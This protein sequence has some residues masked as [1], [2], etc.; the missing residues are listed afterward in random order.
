MTQSLFTPIITHLTPFMGKK[1]S[2]LEFTGVDETGVKYAIRTVS[3]RR[4]KNAPATE[5]FCYALCRLTGIATPEFDIVS[6]TQRNGELAFGSRWVDTDSVFVFDQS[7]Q[8]M[9]DLNFLISKTLL[10]ISSIMALDTTLPNYD[11][12]FGNV[13]FRKNSKE[14]YTAMAFDWSHVYALDSGFNDFDL[15]TSGNKT[16]ISINQFK[17]AGLFK[18]DRILQQID[19]ILSLKPLKIKEIFNQIPQEWKTGIDENGIIHW[20]GA[21]LFHR[22]NEAKRLLL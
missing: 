8:D 19:R 22:T 10:D 3:D 11:R 12:H 13:M 1:T 21:N 2:S 6:L 5:Y 4:F 9:R 17:Q 16:I 18:S 15:E 7:S 14:S 20:W